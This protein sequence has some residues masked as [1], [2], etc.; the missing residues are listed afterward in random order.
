MLMKE[1]FDTPLGRG[2]CEKLAM[3]M[4]FPSFRYGLTQNRIED[5]IN[6]NVANEG[7]DK[8]YMN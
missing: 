8:I 2:M 3:M 5:W 1:K 7:Q 4:I 6:S